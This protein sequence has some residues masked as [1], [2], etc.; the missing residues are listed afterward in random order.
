VHARGIRHLHAPPCRTHKLTCKQAGIFT[1]CAHVGAVLALDPS[2]RGPY[3]A[4]AGLDGTIRLLDTASKTLL[5]HASFPQPATT[6]QW[7]PR[8]ARN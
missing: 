5:Y 3:V 4:T 8:C 2:P 6:L 7:A 1:F